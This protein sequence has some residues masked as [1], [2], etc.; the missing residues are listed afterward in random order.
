MRLSRV[1]I[2]NDKG[3]LEQERGE[4]FE[5]RGGRGLTCKMVTAMGLPSVF[6]SCVIPSLT[7]INPVLLDILVHFLLITP[8]SFA[9]AEE[10]DD[11]VASSSVGRLWCRTVCSRG[12]GEEAAVATLVG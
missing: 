2:I 1:I 7:A 8:G 10:E 12:G 9:M 4:W 5:P 6:Q 3:E 11:D